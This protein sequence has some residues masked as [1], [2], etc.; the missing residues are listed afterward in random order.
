M[1]KVRK[2]ICAFYKPVLLLAAQKANTQNLRIISAL[3]YTS[4]RH[5]VKT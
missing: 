4:L 2:G 5:T 1:A 3:G